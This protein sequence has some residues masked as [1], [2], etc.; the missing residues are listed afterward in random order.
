MNPTYHNL[1]IAYRCL[2][3]E[4]LKSF[5][6]CENMIS[7]SK[8]QRYLKLFPHKEIYRN[9]LNFGHNNFKFYFIQRYPHDRLRLPLNQNWRQMDQGRTW[10]VSLRTQTVWEKLEKNR[11]PH[12]NQNQHPD[13]IP[14]TKVLYQNQK[15]LK[16]L[17]RKLTPIKQRPI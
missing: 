17:R 5:M 2:L 14:C 7:G 8:L 4:K 16:T 11:R 3:F 10:K 6:I 15:I 13:P 9:L 1:L 12:L